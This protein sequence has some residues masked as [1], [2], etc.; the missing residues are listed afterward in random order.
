MQ[1]KTAQIMERKI[2]SEEAEEGF[3]LVEKAW[4]TKLPEPGTPFN[5]NIAGSNLKTR[6]EASG[7]CTCR[8]PEHVHYR[9]PLP[10]M[11]PDQGRT[12]RLRVVKADKLVLDYL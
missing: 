7:P 10:L 1:Q 9:I 3:L 11:N 8:Q 6:I 2:G 12:A 5:L 4:L